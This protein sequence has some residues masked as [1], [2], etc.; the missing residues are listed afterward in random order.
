M[1][2]QTHPHTHKPTH[3]HSRSLTFELAVYISQK[4]LYKRP[5]E[6]VIS[7]WAF[8]RVL[9]QTALCNRV[10]E[11]GERGEEGRREMGERERG[12]REEREGREVERKENI[13]KV[14]TATLNVT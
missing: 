9:F 14:G 6:K 1:W 11:E 8:K 5:P 10:R 12:G 3:A 4:G 13:K 7:K 2:I